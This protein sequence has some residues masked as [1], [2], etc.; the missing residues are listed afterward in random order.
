MC[1]MDHRHRM[2]R[3]GLSVYIQLVYVAVTVMKRVLFMKVV[4]FQG[5]LQQYI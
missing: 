2:W 3:Y 4:L 5:E 1:I